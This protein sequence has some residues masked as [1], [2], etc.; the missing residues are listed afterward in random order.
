MDDG[1]W[2]ARGTTLHGLQEFLE[3]NDPCLDD[4]I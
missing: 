1:T 4:V 2:I 3:E